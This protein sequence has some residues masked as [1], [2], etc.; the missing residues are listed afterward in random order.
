MALSRFWSWM[1]ALSAMYIFYMLA[2]N[3]VYSL[4]GLVNGKQNDPVLMSELPIKEFGSDSVLLMALQANKGASFE[5]SDG[6]FYKLLGTGMVEVGQGKQAADGIFPTCK[7]TIMEIWLPLIGYLTFFCGLLNL[8][9]DS[10]AI[11]KLAGIM[12]PFFA[13]IFPELPKG[14]PAYGFMTMNFAANFLGLDNAATPL[15]CGLW[16]VCRRLIRIKKRRVIVRLCFCVYM[17]PV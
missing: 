12:A 4:N 1:I 2:I 15:V 11:L 7:N 9:N 8:L 13:R 17:L 16:R 14:H 10:N 6:K 5:H 3:Q